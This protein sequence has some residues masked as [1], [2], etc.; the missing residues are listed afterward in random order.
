MQDQKTDLRRLGPR[1]ATHLE[2]EQVNRFGW[3]NSSPLPLLPPVQTHCRFQAEMRT[4]TK[5]RL[6]GLSPSRNQIL[7]RVEGRRVLAVNSCV[8]QDS[9]EL[10]AVTKK[11]KT[12]MKTK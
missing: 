6:E 10:S 11:D 1:K 4:T 2:S 9:P 12:N 5:S 3:S 7:F 8:R